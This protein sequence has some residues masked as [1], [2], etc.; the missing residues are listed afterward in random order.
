MRPE[1]INTSTCTCGSTHDAHAH[2]VL[3][4][5]LRPPHSFV[6][7]GIAGVGATGPVVG[8]AAGLRSMQLPAGKVHG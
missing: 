7:A 8:Y 6:G 2:L 5:A 3:S 1:L 4:N